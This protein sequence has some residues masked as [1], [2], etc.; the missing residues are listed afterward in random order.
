MSRPRVPDGPDDGTVAPWAVLASLPFAPEIAA[1]GSAFQGGLPGDHGQV[2]LQVQLQPELQQE[3]E[4]K[5]GWTSQYHYGINLGPVVSMCENY[6]S[7]LPWQLTRSCP[8]IVTG[9]RRAGFSNG[10]L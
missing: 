5:A 3:S 10:W 1:D 7:G 4:S 2:L 8:Y 6:R 9:L